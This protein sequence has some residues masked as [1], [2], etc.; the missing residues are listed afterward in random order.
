MK[1]CGRAAQCTCIWKLKLSSGCDR[2]I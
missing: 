1:F 2:C